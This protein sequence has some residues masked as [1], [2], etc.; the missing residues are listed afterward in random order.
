[1]NARFPR[2]TLEEMSPAQREVAAEISAGPRGEVRGPFIALIHNA[3]LAR[4]MQALGEQLRWKNR[5]PD[6]L[7]ELAVLYTARQW[8]CQHEWY[9]HEKLARKAG[10]PGT[11]IEAL[12]AGREPDG[13]SEEEALVYRASVQAHATGR[14]DDATFDALA[15]R[16]GREGVLDVL[17]LNGYYSAMAMV[18]NTAGLPLPDNAAPPLKPL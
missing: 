4:R 7:L 16:Y 12:A 9:M 15:R 2:L 11:I 13:M 14:L 5:L 8:S 17:L 1:M 10:L 18:L 3:D 6:A